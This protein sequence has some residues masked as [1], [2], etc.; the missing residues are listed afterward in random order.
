M[1]DILKEVCTHCSCQNLTVQFFQPLASCS[2][3]HSGETLVPLSCFK[4]PDHLVLFSLHLSAASHQVLQSSKFP[5]LLTTKIFLT[6]SFT[7]LFLSLVIFIG[8]CSFLLHVN[9]YMVSYNLYACDSSH[10]ENPSMQSH[11][12]LRPVFLTPE[13]LHQTFCCSFIFMSKTTPSHSKLLII[14]CVFSLY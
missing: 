14:F 3:P 10:H 6:W 7:H 2:F 4:F 12:L 9:E 5:L 13:I 8:S 1:S 11:L